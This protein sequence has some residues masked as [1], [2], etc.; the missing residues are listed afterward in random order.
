MPFSTFKR[1]APALIFLAA[2]GSAPAQDGLFDRLKRALT[3]KQAAAP[4]RR[5][6][7]QRVDVPGPLPDLNDQSCSKNPMLRKAKVTVSE[8]TLKTEEK[9]T[10]FDGEP[11]QKVSGISSVRIHGTTLSVSLT[12][13]GR[14]E[15]FSGPIANIL[16]KSKYEASPGTALIAHTF[17]LGIGLL[18]SPANSAQH[19][20]G[21]TDTRVIRREVITA[22]SAPTGRFEWRNI[23]SVLVVGV[24][25][26]GS[27][28]MFNL[29]IT[30]ANIQRPFE[31]D[32]LPHV[33]QTAVDGPVEITVT[34]LN[35]SPQETPSAGEAQPA[36]EGGALEHQVALRADFSEARA[37]EL[38]RL[39]R[40][41]QEERA[42]R[43]RQIEAERA[44][45]Q[46]KR[47]L[48]GRWT[49]EETCLTGK[50]PAVGLV[51]EVDESGRLSLRHRTLEGDRVVEQYVADDIR[52]RLDSA[53]EQTA[54]LGLYLRF[55]QPGRR[56]LDRT[57]LVKLGGQQM[58]VLDQRDGTSTVIR[59][60]L[61]QSTG[62]PV[63]PL[64]NCAHPRVVAQRAQIDR[65]EQERVRRAQLAAEERRLRQERE[66]AERQRRQEERDRLYRQ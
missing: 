66:E 24:D 59:A 22:E 21:C 4:A 25:G 31:I 57:L 37:A 14:F 61:V 28:K 56:G 26:L 48:A 35:C 16:E 9:H 50:H 1:L 6:Q 33:M 51:F 3:E 47:M 13:Q 38:A 62:R 44:V 63:S 19:A 8:E 17:T 30:P 60:G 32:L 20:L 36:R 65:E 64:T 27:R 12:S 55:L 10:F 42:A 54:E 58:Q 45:L 5:P 7:A 29:N 40:L 34:C 53:L 43:Q 49:S 46:F 52:V 11:S 2:T 18:L 15:E 41:A 23:P 39:E